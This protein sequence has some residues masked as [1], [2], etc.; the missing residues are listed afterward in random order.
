MFKNKDF[1]G[2]PNLLMSI[3]IISAYNS[4]FHFSRKFNLPWVDISLAIKG[5]YS[6]PDVS[7]G[8]FYLSIFLI[9][10]IPALY[11]SIKRC[12]KR[13]KNNEISIQ[14]ARLEYLKSLGEFGGALILLLIFLPIVVPYLRGWK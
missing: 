4:I 11:I 12:F 13:I 5:R 3:A 2:V 10:F 1:D 9:C 7:S 8:N 14:K 6:S